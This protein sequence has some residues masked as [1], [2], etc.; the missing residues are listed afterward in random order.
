MQ[1]PTTALPHRRN[2]AST[3]LK[4]TDSA[5]CFTSP[6]LMQWYLPDSWPAEPEGLTRL[7]KLNLSCWNTNSKS[8]FANKRLANFHC[9]FC[10]NQ[11]VL[12]RVSLCRH[13]V[14]HPFA[15]CFLACASCYLDLRFF[16]YCVD[17]W[18]SLLCVTSLGNAFRGPNPRVWDQAITESKSV[19]DYMTS[20]YSCSW[21][22][23]NVDW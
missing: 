4:M 12:L 20:L 16:L 3:F 17:A 22:Q 21:R 13:T 1:N 10:K 7:S 18:A 9:A 5:Y 2:T 11:R 15:P 8:T 23:K 6:R 19:F 14:C